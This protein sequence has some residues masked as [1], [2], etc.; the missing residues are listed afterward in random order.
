[1]LQTKVVDLEIFLKTIYLN[2]SGQ[3]QIVGYEFER[4]F[5]TFIIFYQPYTIK[6]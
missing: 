6:W 4:K 5:E 2:M 1:M 3:A